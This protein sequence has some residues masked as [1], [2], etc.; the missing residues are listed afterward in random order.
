MS[1]F[2]RRSFFKAA[3]VATGTAMISISPAAAAAI[4]PGALETT[5]S[6]PLPQEP[7]V[8]VIRNAELG[9]VTVLSGR[10]E[11]TYTD[12][13]LVKRLLKAAS[14]NHHSGQGVA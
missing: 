3:G 10:T 14:K 1:T 7:I 13:L 5:P 2:S 6:G 11:K 8:A 9:E 4:E 12:K